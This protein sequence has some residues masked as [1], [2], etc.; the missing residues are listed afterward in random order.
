MMRF[1]FTITLLALLKLLFSAPTA[2]AQQWQFR[3]PVVAGNSVS[4]QDLLLAPDI[5]ARLNPDFGNLRLLDADSTEVPFLFTNPSA[6][7]MDAQLSWYPTVKQDYYRRWYSKSFF[8]VPGAKVID[9]MVLKIRNADVRQRFWLSGSDDMNRW[10]IIKEDFVYDAGYDPTSSYNLLTIDFPPVNYKYYKVE[11]RHHW[12]EPI[13]IMGAGFYDFRQLKGDFTRV[14]KPTILQYEDPNTRQSVVDIRYDAPHYMDQLVFEV[15]GPELYHRAATLKRRVRTAQGTAWMDVVE[16]FTLRSGKINQLS[17][18]NLRTE[19]LQLVIDNKDDKPLR[20][21]G[22]STFQTQ[23]FITAKLHPKQQY[24]LY[25]GAE[26][27][28]A[29]EYDLEYFR[30]ALPAYRRSRR[31]DSL[32]LL[33]QPA[34]P[35]SAK[36]PSAPAPPAAAGDS[37]AVVPAEAESAGPLLQS[38]AFL[39]AG[40][41]AMM[42]LLGYF[43]VKMLGDIK[44]R[45]ED[46]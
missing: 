29:P 25:I 4:Y 30:D 22:A 28:R 20:I 5:T 46:A 35:A 23:K 27:L 3:A 13:Q 8:R 14:P 42:L 1:K 18:D 40:I 33:L 17:F 21:A 38:E 12:R 16:N 41:V 45:E 19:S 10:F 24:H 32:E 2:I 7:E 44:A 6:G 9:R 11:L 34:P 26:R 31:V 37:A 39:W 36:R 43:S 15:D